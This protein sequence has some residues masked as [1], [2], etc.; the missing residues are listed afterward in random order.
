MRL[1]RV[2]LMLSRGLRLLKEEH[3]F[4]KCY[5]VAHS[6]GGL[7]ARRAIDLAVA[8]EGA[9]FIPKFVSISTP[10]G[11]HPAAESGLRHLKK[12]VPSW[13]DVAPESAY[14]HSLHSVPPPAGTRHWLFYGQK[15]KRLPWLKGENDGVVQVKSETDPRILRHAAGVKVYPFQHEEILFQPAVLRD[16]EAALASP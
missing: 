13:L 1:E 7:V 12:P 15:T 14:L 3:G 5:V 16:V 9:D 2:A 4:T 10:W 6:M 11:G 8:D